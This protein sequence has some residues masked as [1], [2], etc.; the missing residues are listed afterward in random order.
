MV[1]SLISDTAAIEKIA[2]PLYPELDK[3][4][5]YGTA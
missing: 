4:K 5:I 3:T 1:L 2:V